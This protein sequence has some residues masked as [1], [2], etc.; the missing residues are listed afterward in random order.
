M[1]K[2][3]Q[4]LTHIA[5]DSLRTFPGRHSVVFLSGSTLVQ[6]RNLELQS[7]SLCED[8]IVKLCVCARVCVCVCVYN[9][10]LVGT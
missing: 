3:I 10:M 7:F 2:V 5:H 1:S 9:S 6:T 8:Q 4:E